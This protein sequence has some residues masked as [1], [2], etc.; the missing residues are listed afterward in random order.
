MR[1]LIW[2]TPLILYGLFFGWYT[3]L[4]GPLTDDEIAATVA[5]MEANGS[6]AERIALVKKFMVEDTGGQ[7]LMMNVIEMKDPP[8]QIRG[9][10]PTDTADDVMAK[11]ME[12]M[13]PALLNRACHPVVFGLAV[14][15]S[16]DLMGIEGA[17]VWTQAA[18]MRYRSRRDMLEI[19]GNP[20]FSGRH[21][22]KFAAMNKTIA[23]PV[24]PTINLGDPRILLGLLALFLSSILFAFTARG[25]R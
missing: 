15:D 17:E 16:L 22:F 3:N 13:W 4:S 10:E 8:D 23:Y 12:Y 18:F 25:P 5:R 21:E 2:L 20:E 1:H 6:T 14:S 24:E 7:F 19:S 9:V 11:Y